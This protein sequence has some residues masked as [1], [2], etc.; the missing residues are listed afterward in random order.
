M[1]KQ[2]A[3]FCRKCAGNKKKR[4]KNIGP[5]QAVRK[6]APAMQALERLSKK[7]VFTMLTLPRGSAHEIEIAQ[8]FHVDRG[9]VP[10]LAYFWREKVSAWELSDDSCSAQSE[11]ILS[12][13]PQVLR[14]DIKIAPPCRCVPISNLHDSCRWVFCLIPLRFQHPCIPGRPA[15]QHQNFPKSRTKNVG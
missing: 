15:A 6:K 12:A 9:R 7:S 3:H 2:F 14:Q 10:R 8:R 5:L 13:K 1:R 11:H 4:E